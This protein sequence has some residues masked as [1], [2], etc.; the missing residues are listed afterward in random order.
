MFIDEARIHVRGGHG[1]N[2]CVSFRREKYEPKGGPDGGDG[3]AGGNV[4]MKVDEGL[5][6]LMDFNYRRHFFAA[7]G[8]HGGG[9]NKHGRTGKDIT[10]KVPPGT[11]VKDDKGEVLA[12]LVDKGQ[13]FTVARGG[14][15]GK[16]NKRFASSSN[17]APKE[18]QP[19][20][21]GEERMIDLEL[22]ILADVAIVGLPNA[23]KST[24]INRITAA[25]A[26]V[27]DYPFTTKTP[28]LGVV[29]LEDGRDFVVADIPGLVEGAHKGK[30]MGIRFLRHIERA[31]FIIHLIDVSENEPETVIERYNTLN[32]ELASYSDHLAGLDQIVVAN[33]ID[34]I[35]G[36]SERSRESRDVLKAVADH[37]KREGT[38][39]YAVSALTGKGIDS[40][41]LVIADKIDKIREQ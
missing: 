16:G 29:F 39:F 11:V 36:N 41:L 7:K 17:R 40:L 10:L 3:G 30:G 5:K 15:G 1:G 14:R 2:G 23:G 34:L 28:N 20:E 32:E 38:E 31:G 25:K 6:T 37:F 9:G 33:K 4:I 12:D 22:K 26:K 35:T 8:S 24:L 21:P 13:V 19:G 18:A 27:A